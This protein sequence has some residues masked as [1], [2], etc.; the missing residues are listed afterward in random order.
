MR[1]LHGPVLCLTTLSLLGG[2]ALAHAAP[3]K[4]GPTARSKRVPVVCAS[5]VPTK[6]QCLSAG[7][8]DAC[9]QHTNACRSHV[10]DA[11]T[12]FR[13]SPA[14]KKARTAKMLRPH[15]DAIPQALRTG[16]EFPYVPPTRTR[17]APSANGIAARTK[18]TGP[19]LAS[20]ADTAKNAH[21]NKAWEKNGDR[22]K[23][24]EEYAYEQVYDWARFVDASAACRGDWRCQIDLAY[25][26]S[27]PGIA[28]RTLRRK[29]GRPLAEQVKQ[30]RGPVPKNA[31]FQLDNELII[32]NIVLSGGR[33]A[34]TGNAIRLEETA[35]RRALIQ[36]LD[37]GNKHYRF[38]CKGPSCGP[39]EYDS[40]FAFHKARYDEHRTVSMAE[41]E[42]FER[43][44][45]KF[46][47]LL[48]E[49]SAAVSEEIEAS[50][51]KK[52]RPVHELVLPLDPLVNPYDTNGI[53][54]FALKNSIGG[55]ASKTR[56][57]K[58][59][60]PKATP[61][62]KGP[63]T[64]KRRRGERLERKRKRR[65]RRGALN[66]SRPAPSSVFAASGQERWKGLAQEPKR[67]TG[68]D[69][70]HQ[71]GQGRRLQVV[72]AGFGA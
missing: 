30:K 28:D 6:T 21:R 5:G 58:S 19:V 69:P 16:K 44:K 68:E 62:K 18:L 2:V 37:Q 3:A 24:C 43:R 59:A 67:R 38:G 45:A 46:N 56:T 26:R 41:F 35:D 71:A 42:E 9:T 47:R 61:T 4:R 66:E 52:K 53:V 57:K 17:R 1:N 49:W 32:R 13:A 12:A 54:R 51:P 50:D 29:D 60:T 48:M 22:V 8:L 23:T 39:R 34:S 40:E 7:Y 63:A 33:S 10:E 15:K 20:S 11:F 31:M 65:R 72:E 36:Q 25:M 27:T 55:K 70:E 64:K 14:Y